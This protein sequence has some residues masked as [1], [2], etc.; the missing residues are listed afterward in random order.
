MEKITNQVEKLFSDK[1]QWDSFLELAPKKDTIKNDWYYKLSPPLIQSFNV[2]DVIEEWG[3]YSNPEDFR[4]YI[5]DFGNDSLYLAFW[6][7]EFV[8]FA[9]GEVLQIEAIKQKLRSKKY[10]PILSAFERLD[11]CLDGDD[12]GYLLKEIGNFSF[13]DPCDKNID[14]YSLSWYANYRNVDFV[15]QIKSKVDK[16]RKNQEVMKLFFD[17]YNLKIENKKRK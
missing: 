12:D 13:G 6:G 4:W 3:F 9:N 16:F 8:L 1:E 15:N 10:S 2:D 14:I 17:L 7:N 11:Y 5:K